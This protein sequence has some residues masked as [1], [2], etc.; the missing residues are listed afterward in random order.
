MRSSALA[1]VQLTILD[2]EDA[3]QNNHA[4]AHVRAQSTCIQYADEPIWRACLSSLGPI[5]HRVGTYSLDP[6]RL[7]PE[8]T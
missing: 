3:I 8:I 7:S 6:T 5:R 1:D 4:M 2:R